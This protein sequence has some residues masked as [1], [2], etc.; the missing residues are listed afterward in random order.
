MTHS[1]IKKY[2]SEMGKR[3]VQAKKDKYGEEGFRKLLSR[4]G[5]APKKGKKQAIKPLDK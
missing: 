5:K 2:F 1:L 3:G 4:A